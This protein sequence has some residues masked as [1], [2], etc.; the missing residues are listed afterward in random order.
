MKLSVRDC[1]TLLEPM[2]FPIEIHTIKSGWFIVYIL[3]PSADSFKKGC[4]LLQAK[5]CAQTTS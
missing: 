4:C 3:L 1:L 2:E 5:V